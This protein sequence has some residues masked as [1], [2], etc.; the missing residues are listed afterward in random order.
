M[1]LLLQVFYQLNIFR[2]NLRWLWFTSP[3]ITEKEMCSYIIPC[4]YHWYFYPW[5]LCAHPQHHP[6]Q[7]FACI[8]MVHGPVLEALVP[9]W[10]LVW[11]QVFD[12]EIWKAWRTSIAWSCLW[13]LSSSLDQELLTSHSLPSL[14]LWFI[15]FTMFDVGT[16]A[17]WNTSRQIMICC[18]CNTTQL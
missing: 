14:S 5:A 3:K 7:A 18:N 4:H 2:F 15:T 16:L 13:I 1:A 11:R 12:W 10:H 6:H 17:T 9:N 8:P